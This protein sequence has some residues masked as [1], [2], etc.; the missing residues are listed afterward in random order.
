MSWMALVEPWLEW[1]NLVAFDSYQLETATICMVTEFGNHHAMW[2]FSGLKGCDV[3]G[4][5]QLK[6]IL[7]NANNFCSV[8]LEIT[9]ECCLGF[10]LS[11]QSIYADYFIQLMWLSIN[12]INLYLHGLKKHTKKSYL[13]YGSVFQW[14]FVCLSVS[15]FKPHGFGWSPYSCWV[16]EAETHDFRWGQTASENYISLLLKW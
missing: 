16:A 8:P 12:S 15:T 6:Y 9:L 10:F 7:N 13:L 4:C 5:I 11:Y 2:S 3:C 1:R 14:G